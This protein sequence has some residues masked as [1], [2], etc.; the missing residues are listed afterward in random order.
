MVSLT[1][2]IYSSLK[3]SKAATWQY[4]FKDIVHSHKMTEMFNK[5]LL[6]PT[7][8]RLSVLSKNEQVLQ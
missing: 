5:H 1:S 7:D 2:Q 4:F 8:I 3:T 6:L